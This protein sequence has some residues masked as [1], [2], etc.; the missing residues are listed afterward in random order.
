MAYM[1][2]GGNVG[3]TIDHVNLTAQSLVH[4]LWNSKHVEKRNRVHAFGLI[5]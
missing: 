2:V 3:S 4:N 5:A 1:E